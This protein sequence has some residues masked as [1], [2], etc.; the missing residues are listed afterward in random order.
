MKKNISL[1]VNVSQGEEVYIGTKRKQTSPPFWKLGGNMG[2]NRSRFPVYDGDLI[3]TMK[4]ITK[5]A[6][7]MFWSL[8]ETRSDKTNIAILTPQD[9]T[10]TQKVTRAYKEL[11]NKDIIKRVRRSHYIINPAVIQPRIEHYEEVYLKW[12]DTKG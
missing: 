11:S 3:D 10:E 2:Y 9:P 12:C 1:K 5:G 6:N 7:W 8:L 4:N